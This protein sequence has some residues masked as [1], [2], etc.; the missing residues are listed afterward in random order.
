ML[1]AVGIALVLILSPTVAVADLLVYEGF[2]YDEGSLGGQNGGIGFA[3]GWSSGGTVAAGSLSYVDGNSNVLPTSGNHALISAAS[4]SVSAYRDLTRQYGVDAVYGPGVY[5]VSFI[6]QRNQPHA[7]L[8]ENSAR[9]AAFQ[10]HNGT[11]TSGD[12]RLDI[13]KVTTSAPTVLYN[14]ALFAGGTTDRYSETSTP[15]TDLAFF[16]SAIT[17]ADSTDGN[18]S[19]TAQL[20]VDPN[21]DEPLGTPDAELTGDDAFDFIFQRVRLWAGNTSGGNPYA[22]WVIDEIRIGTT[23]EDAIGIVPLAGDTDG[24]GVVE[25]DDDLDPIRANY[26]QSVTNRNL[27]DLTGDLFVDFSDFRQWKTAYLE[28]GGS[29][30]GVNLGFLTVPEPSSLVLWA[31]VLAGAVVARRR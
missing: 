3:S 31:L 6:G 22:E 10:L 8:D 18:L 4:A 1:L 5:W 15:M 28:V 26:L 12:E 30:A 23:F 13:G 20:W 2:D 11:G 21:L 25:L 29:L 24:D 7:T 14:W 9:S 27:G 17:I 19:D 16:V